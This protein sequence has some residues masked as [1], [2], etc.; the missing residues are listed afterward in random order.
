VK[1]PPAGGLKGTITK[2]EVYRV[3]VFLEP[4]WRI[5]KTNS[6]L[7]ALR[8]WGD[9]AEFNDSPIPS[10]FLT[11]PP[12]G[13]SMLE[14][15]LS[16]YAF[17]NAGVSPSPF[18]YRTPAGIGVAYG[19]GTGAGG[20]AHADQFLKVM[21]EL[22]LPLNARLEL[23]ETDTGT[24][25]EVLNES[26]SSFR[27]EEELEFTAV[28][29]SRFLPPHSTWCNSKG[30]QFSFD[31]VAEKLLSRPLGEGACGGVHVL[32][33]L[34]NLLRVDQIFRILDPS[35]AKHIETRLDEVS[36]I[37]ERNQSSEGAWLLNWHKG[38][39]VS[40][41]EPWGFQAVW[42]T[43]HH[44]EWIAL[45]TPRL[46]PSERT[47]KKAASLL[48]NVIPRHTIDT[49]YESYAPFS[50]AAR[51]LLLIEELEPGALMK[52]FRHQALP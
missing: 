40:T 30:K 36:R 51:A 52:E 39:D 17:R 15:M 29:Y 24:L 32:Y 12:S 48:A 7:H 50:H 35:T 18:L 14:V 21:G 27:L 19:Y 42:I 46:R 2:W 26:I 34:T 31:V 25:A 9:N 3:L 33:A 4:R 43:G 41:K 16:N 37:L 47:I 5:S 1:I 28:A 38:K 6:I 10:K 23:S 45:A 44:L 49:I 22:G 20:V 11:I 13:K 8:L